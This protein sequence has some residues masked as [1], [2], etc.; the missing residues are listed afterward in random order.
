C[1][2]NEPFL[3]RVI[4][5]LGE[6]LLMFSSDYPHADRS[7]GTASYLKNRNDISKVAR[8]KLLADNA[9]RFYGI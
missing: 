9:Q 2:G 8:Q 3:P 4:D 1:E 5:D 7:E 6:D